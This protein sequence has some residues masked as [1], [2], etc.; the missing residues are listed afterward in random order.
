MSAK[1]RYRYAWAGVLLSLGAPAGLVAVRAARADEPSLA[2]LRAELAV[3]A[4]VYVYVAGSTLAA[5]AAFGHVLGRQA[6]R[7]ARLARTDA[8][9]GLLNRR[10]FEERLAEEWERAVRYGGRLSLLLIDL[11]GLKAV[12]DRAGHRQGD[13]ALR[14]VA[15]GLRQDCRAVDVAA[16]WGGDEFAVL[17]PATAADEALELAE[18]VRVSAT[19]TEW[20][21]SIGLSSLDPGRSET[22]EMLLRRAD[23]A[24]YAAKRRG[25]NRVAAG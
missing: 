18:R 6:D 13:L 10:A 22:A 8:L 7:L 9:T 17:A 11:D 24:L 2:W 25:R 19:R 16:R 15:D 23:A 14:A 12:N 3:E 1:R 5:F 4:P 20:T 21:V